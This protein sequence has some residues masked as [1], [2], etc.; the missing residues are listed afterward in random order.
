MTQEQ[1]SNLRLVGE[2]V[3]IEQHI[4]PKHSLVILP[5]NKPTPDTYTITSKVVKFSP[6]AE[7]LI[8]EEGISLPI[9]KKPYFASHMQPEVVLDESDIDEKEGGIAYI[10]VNYRHIIGY[11]LSN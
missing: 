11:D 2:R 4:K 7:E 8:R 6:A 10:V 1:L 3:L 5:N 9:G